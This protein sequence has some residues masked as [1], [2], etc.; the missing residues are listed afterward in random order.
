M[1]HELANVTLRWWIE[2][3]LE[4]LRDIEPDARPTVTREAI[5][6]LE[7]ALAGRPIGYVRPI[8]GTDGP[9]EPYRAPFARNPRMP[10]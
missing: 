7:D 4:R 3:A 5:E 9:R 8:P 1:D 6:W 10:R 2:G